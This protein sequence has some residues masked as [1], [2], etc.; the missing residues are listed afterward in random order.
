MSPN[1]K[2]DFSDKVA[3]VTGMFFVKLK[4]NFY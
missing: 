4:Y 2:Y 1:K 3:L